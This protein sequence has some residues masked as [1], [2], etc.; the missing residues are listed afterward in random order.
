MKK[1]QS[2]HDSFASPP[3]PLSI[4]G[5]EVTCYR[6]PTGG[7]LYIGLLQAECLQS[8]GRR[9]TLRPVLK[10]DDTHDTRAVTPSPVWERGTGGEGNGG[11]NRV[12]IY[13][14]GISANMDCAFFANNFVVQ[15]MPSTTLTPGQLYFTVG[16]CAVSIQ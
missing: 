1:Y 11:Y 12:G 4:N 2:S 14:N 5:E 6:N 9:E 15:N 10:H 3:G 8:I 7:V 16:T 13:G